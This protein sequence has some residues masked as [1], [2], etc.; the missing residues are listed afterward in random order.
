MGAALEGAFP[1]A[2]DPSAGDRRIWAISAYTLSA[3]SALLLLL[4]LVMIRR[5]RV[6][7]APASAA[8][9]ATHA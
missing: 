6:R 1:L 7:A 8:L 3:L 2:A 5:I 9:C 4:T